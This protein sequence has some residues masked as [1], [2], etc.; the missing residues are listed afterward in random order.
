MTSEIA[1]RTRKAKDRGEGE[2]NTLSYRTSLVVVRVVS[3]AEMLAVEM[4]VV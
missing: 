4:V 2:G 1:K 3:M